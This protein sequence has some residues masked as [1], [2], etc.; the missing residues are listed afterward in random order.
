MF[1]PDTRKIITNQNVSFIEPMD[2][3]MPRVD[4]YNDE[5][6]PSTC[7]SSD[8]MTSRNEEEKEEDGVLHENEE[9]SDTEE[10]DESTSSSSSSSEE[11][12]R[13]VLRSNNRATGQQDKHETRNKRQL[14]E[15]RGLALRGQ[16]ANFVHQCIKLRTLDKP[17]PRLQYPHLPLTK[18]PWGRWTRRCFVSRSM[19]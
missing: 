2:M 4:S 1:N 11:D 5:E 14:A 13:R 12:N 18:K 16:L 8:I 10:D 6:T 19:K 9:T 7:S 17:Y 15:L 3:A